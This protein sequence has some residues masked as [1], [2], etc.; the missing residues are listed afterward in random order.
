MPPEFSPLPEEKKNV[1]KVENK[2]QAL[3]KSERR[4]W[5]RK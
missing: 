5:S 4:V 1:E 2:I 3:E